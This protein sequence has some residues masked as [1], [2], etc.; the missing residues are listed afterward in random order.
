MRRFNFYSPA[1]RPTRRLAPFGSGERIT[2]EELAPL[3]IPASR[4][5]IGSETSVSYH[6]TPALSRQQ[7]WTTDCNYRSTIG[8]PST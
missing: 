8:G 4:F 2:L 5:C 6:Q 3:L 1:N 7:R